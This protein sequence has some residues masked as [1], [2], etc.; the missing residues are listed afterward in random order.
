MKD[1]PG[2]GWRLAKDFQITGAAPDPKFMICL[3]QM[4]PTQREILPVGVYRGN[5]PEC[6]T[7]RAVAVSASAEQSLSPGPKSGANTGFPTQVS[8]SR[9]VSQTASMRHGPVLCPAPPRVGLTR[10]IHDRRTAAFGASRH[11]CAPPRRSLNWTDG[12]RS[13][14]AAGT[15]LQCPFGPLAVINNAKNENELQDRSRLGGFGGRRPRLLC[16]QSLFIPYH[17]FQPA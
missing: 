8:R 1:R 12:G 6:R 4:C 13:S 11:Y 3:A 17:L 2:T 9:W 7:A 10:S 15:D 16:A 14:S 5:R